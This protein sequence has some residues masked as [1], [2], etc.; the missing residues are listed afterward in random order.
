MEGKM[1]FAIGKCELV[2]IVTCEDGT[3]KYQFD[4]DE[5]F[6]KNY[7][8]MMNLPE[9]DE[10]HFE[11]SFAKVMETI[12]NIAENSFFEKRENNE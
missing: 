9:F 3:I 4:T 8:M 11:K 1:D 12:S 10:S 5:I 2:D 6:R 7:A